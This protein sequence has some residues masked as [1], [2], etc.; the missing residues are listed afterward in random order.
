MI[1]MRRG[2]GSFYHRSV[3][4]SMAATCVLALA[5]LTATEALAQDAPVSPGLALNRFTPAPAGDRM[6]GVQSPYVA[7]HLK[8][9]KSVV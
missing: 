9:R 1:Q 3:R 7:G 2:K 6:F 8:D 5:S 4:R